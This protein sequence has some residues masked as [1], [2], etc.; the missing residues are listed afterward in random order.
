MRVLLPLIVAL[1]GCKGFQP[2]S[3]DSA[4]PSVDR[5]LG[6]G[7]HVLPGGDAARRETAPRDRSLLDGVV[8]ASCRAIPL[9]CLDPAD[10][11][12]IEVPSEH[13]K[14]DAAFA[15]AKAGDTVQV[16]GLSVGAG[17][18]IPA[19]VTLRGCGG[20]KL[21]GNVRFAGSGGIVEGFEIG[22]AGQVVANA[23]GSYL[24]RF[25]RV[26]ASTLTSEAPV[27]GR[28]IDGL[29]S[30][31]VTL[32]VEGNWFE[33]G[34]R[35]VEARTKYDTGTHSVALTV[36]NNVFSGV[37]R[38]LDAA[39]SGLVGKVKLSIEHNTFRDFETA[40][41]LYGLSDT[42]KVAGALLVNGA[43]GVEGGPLEVQYSLCHGVGTT[44]LQPPLT[45]SFATGDPQLGAGLVPG[46][47]PARDAIPAAASVP[48]EDYYGCPRPV[49]ATGG[50]A[51]ADIG[52]VEAQP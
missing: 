9:P 16:K 7:E 35:G 39:R 51:K 5:E 20:A 14:L 43:V 3:G 13:G 27:S 8:A 37:D 46:A 24:V 29:V 42:T 2:A 10:S 31:D 6:A 47:G 11:K 21:L 34:A 23:T 36:R 40:I 15:A 45:G 19:Y 17:W 52:A 25:N 1:A 28:S 26:A 48:A 18:A 38:P 49:A 32:V 41:A 22:G 33:G 30:A 50:E 12:V 44:S 4:S